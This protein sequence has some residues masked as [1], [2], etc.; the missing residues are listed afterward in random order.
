M[1]FWWMS[2]RTTVQTVKP[3]DLEDLKDELGQKDEDKLPPIAQFESEENPNQLHPDQN[4]SA[5]PDAEEAEETGVL[6]KE[7]EVSADN[8]QP[9]TA[10][11]HDNDIKVSQIEASKESLKRP[12]VLFEYFAGKFES[13]PDFEGLDCMK[14]GI[15]PNL[16]VNEASESEVFAEDE[17]TANGNYAVRFRT[18]LDV[19]RGG[20]YTFYT[21]SNDGSSLFIDGNKVV[22][23]DGRHYCREKWGKVKLSPGL[24]FLSVHF[25]HRAGK[26]LEGIRTGPFLRV[27]YYCAGSAWPLSTALA[28]QAIPQQAMAVDLGDQRFKGAAERD[29]P[30]YGIERMA[31]ADTLA[32]QL[33][34]VQAMVAQAKLFSD[35]EERDAGEE[36][37]GAGI[38]AAMRSHLAQVDTLKEMY[39]S[40]LALSV[41]MSFQVMGR[42]VDLP[43]LHDLYADVQRDRIPIRGWGRWISDLLNKLAEEG[44]Q[45]QG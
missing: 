39:F 33:N 45:R 19:K 31:S 10:Q 3:D 5:Q 7:T 23:N 27:S 34:L 24:H 36:A 18:L 13:I 40:S 2:N 30:R 21:E 9:N 38:E 8:V 32:Q 14:V 4:I 35:A 25:F 20:L 16:T 22:D 17:H 28:K 1:A 41:K 42:P 15:V 11:S 6:T 43:D 44:S 26:L 29:C 37:E 12:G